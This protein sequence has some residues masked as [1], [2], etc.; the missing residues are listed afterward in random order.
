MT[1]LILVRIFFVITLQPKSDEL[2]TAHPSPSTETV[3]AYR[4]L[5]QHW[6]LS[7][8]VGD[9][10][11]LRRV[12]RRGVEIEKFIPGRDLSSVHLDYSGTHCGQCGAVDGRG[13]ATFSLYIDR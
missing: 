2:L 4:H 8:T 1:G 6:L 9:L 3:I 12:K 7:P 13:E 5:E 11:K 10:G